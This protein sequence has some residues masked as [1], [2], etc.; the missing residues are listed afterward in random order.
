MLALRLGLPHYD[1]GLMFRVVAFLRFDH[2]WVSID[3]LIRENL[4]S[5]SNYGVVLAGSNISTRLI[6]EEVGLAA[7]RLATV[8]KVRLVE[9]AKA[10]VRHDSFVADG[11][12]VSRIFP[13][14][15]WHFQV[16]VAQEAARER[17][18]AQGGDPDLFDQRWQLDADRLTRAP[19]AIII[20][21]T[22]KT[23]EQSLQVILDC[24]AGTGSVEHGPFE[25]PKR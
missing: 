25:H 19:G 3:K 7:A 11:R 24:L 20:D 15:D 4:L 17:R 9:T 21:T 16:I 8:E 13:N 2:E 12:T 5:V 1:F 23:P 14:A 6:Q 18:R 22:E 10:F